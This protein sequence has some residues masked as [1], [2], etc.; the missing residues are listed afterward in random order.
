VIGEEGVVSGI[1]GAVGVGS[2]DVVVAGVLGTS[3]VEVSVL[4]VDEVVEV[5]SGA[6]TGAVFVN[7]FI[8]T[9][10]ADNFKVAR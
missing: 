2:T 8:F 5:T 1:V 7:A 9:K 4:M 3:R 6:F 10:P